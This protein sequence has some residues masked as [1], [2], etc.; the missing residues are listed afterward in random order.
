MKFSNGCWMDKEGHVI[1][2]P[3]EVYD[4]KQED[5]LLTMYTPF[6][7]INH[8]GQTLDGGILTVEISSP[9]ENI[10]RVKAY[11]HVGS[12]VNDPS[13]TVAEKSPAVQ[14]EETE[15]Q[16]TF[17][18]GTLHATIEREHWRVHFSYKD[19]SLTSSEPRSLS[20]VHND[21]N[22]PYM[23]EQLSLDVGEL[24]Y[25]LGERFTPFVKNGQVV[26]I[27]NEDGGTGSEQTYK[28]IPFYVSNKGYGVFVNHPEHV[29][30]EVASEKVS[31]SQFSVAGECLDYYIV[32]GDSLK[33]VLHNYTE[34][35]GKPPLVPSWSFGLW[36]STSFLTN[37]DEKTV[38]SFVDEMIER[39]IPLDVFH[40]D[41]LWMKELEWCNFEWDERVF[42]DPI[43]MLKR[44]K[45]KGLKICVWINPYIGQKSPLF[46]EAA[47]QGFL[48]KKADGRVWQ[49]DKWQAGMG[50]VDFTNPEATSWYTDKLNGLIDMGVDSFK[51]D[52]GERIPVDVVYADGSCPNKMHNYYTQLYNESVFNLLKKR[53][54]NEQAVLFARSATVGGQT[55]P[56]HWG[57]DSFSN[58]SSMAETLRGGLSLSLAGFAYWSH[59]IGGFETGSTPDL[60][61]RWTQFGLLSSHSRYHGSGDYKVPWLYDEEAVD[62]TRQ[63]TKL[64]CRLMP[65]LYSMAVAATKTGVPMLRPMVLEF[66]EDETCHYLDR[67]Y[68]LGSDLLVAPI[69]N[70]Q[71]TVKYYLPEGEWTNL[72]TNSK[73]TGER[74]ITE[75]HDYTTLPLMVKENSILAFGHED[76]T[77][78]YDF[79]NEVELHLFALKEGEEARMVLVNEAGEEVG[80]ATAL[81]SDSSIKVQTEGLS[82]SYTVVLRNVH[83]VQSLT[84][85]E[86]GQTSDGVTISL[87]S[88]VKEVTIQL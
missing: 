35:T 20:Y 21:K 54:G 77:A 1:K 72:L 16:L 7:K 43:N 24:I 15:E 26:D 83:S 32:A 45:E 27:W 8:I 58:Y 49:W 64:K 66:T 61:K 39:E 25:G 2:S 65:Y 10:I 78:A 42:P 9:L 68:M 31:K 57:G 69:F 6:Q 51:T 33:D 13:F 19:K 74:W 34:L 46:K 87:D 84:T 5:Q 50:L 23:R 82:T 22:E 55:L 18:S 52:F 60:Y 70:D 62:I 11:H 56:V 73:V 75:S 41:C 38:T 59:D 86:Q 30:F 37:Y 88:D 12:V 71:G 3:A 14:L 76:T 63:F 85:G 47:D 40:F 48:L 17:T 79:T 53:L 29:S 44:L 28:N 4:W 80:F 36:L 81:K 67:Q